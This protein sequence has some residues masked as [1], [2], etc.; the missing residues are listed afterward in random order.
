MTTSGS[1]ACA[2]SIQNRATQPTQPPQPGAAEGLGRTDSQPTYT[3]RSPQT[4]QPVSRV[5]AEP[6]TCHER[7]AVP[8]GKIRPSGGAPGS[9]A[10]AHRPRWA[11]PW[12]R[13]P[14]S[15]ITVAPGG[16]PTARR[17]FATQRTSRS[18]RFVVRGPWRR[19][20]T[21][22]LVSCLARWIV[23]SQVGSP[24]PWSRL[25][26]PLGALFWPGERRL[27]A[28]S[29]SR[30]RRPNGSGIEARDRPAILPQRHPSE[31]GNQLTRT[32]P[33]P[34]ADFKGHARSL[35]VRASRG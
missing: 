4:A 1:S 28:C 26:M 17:S 29:C 31:V 24:F 6:Y 8:D 10:R 19:L 9:I 18:A 21:W 34:L 7:P 23:A 2:C 16:R 14:S 27:R 13:S 35:A 11:P 3:P 30:G 33:R 32:R 22:R 12:A 5:R 15:R 20:R 25:P